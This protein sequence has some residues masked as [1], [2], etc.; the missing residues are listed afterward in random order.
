M[1]LKAAELDYAHLQLCIAGEDCIL[2]GTSGRARYSPSRTGEALLISG[3]RSSEQVVGGVHGA[4]RKRSLRN[5]HAAQHQPIYTVG[6][7]GTEAD[8]KVSREEL[9]GAEVDFVPR[10]G[11]TTFHGPG[12][13]CVQ[14][15]QASHRVL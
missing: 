3:H 14:V 8:F 13:V 1:W 7:R 4:A 9:H 11:E 10:G 5:I 6:K 12:Q 15:L 2:G